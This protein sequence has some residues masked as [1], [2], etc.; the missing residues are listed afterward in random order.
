MKIALFHNLPPGGAKR[1]L[2]EHARL[3][4]ERGHV[5][6]AYIMSTAT[7]DYLS[8]TPLCRRVFV[9]DA[10][11]PAPGDRL[12]NNPLW[13]WTGQNVR[14]MVGEARRVRREVARLDALEATYREL[15][16]QIDAGGYDLVYVHHCRLL[17]S[18]ALLRFLKTPSV[19][20]CHDTLRHIHEWAVEEH[21]DYDRTPPKL[22]LSLVHGHRV[23]LPTL[24]LWWDQDRRNTASAR[25]ATMV[26]ANSSYSREA[27]LKSMGVN[28][29]VCDLGIDSEFFRPDPTVLRRHEVLSVG[30]IAPLKR[31][32][33]ILDA[34]ATIPEDRRPAMR[35]V[36]YDPVRY[37]EAKMSPEAQALA[38]RACERGVTLRF[39]KEVTDELV[40]DAY[41]SAG[42]VAFAPY[43]EPFGFVPL[44]AMACGAAVVGV[45]E[46]GVRETITDGV[47]GLLTER[48]VETF[49]AA[50]DRV[51][52]DPA[53][54]ERLGETGCRTVRE[55]WTW[56]R[57]ADRMEFLFAQAIKQT[58]LTS[59][60][61][62]EALCASR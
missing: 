17:L 52:T 60:A 57:S 22:G 58:P 32:D 27:I 31:H 12:M 39:S 44:E 29:R 40:R 46:A 13:R 38:D 1:A 47:T 10:P 35:I 19:Y 61:K 4:Q 2:W 20:F 26:F 43:L 34:I 15:A 8:L 56:E 28:A 37:G 59:A 9:H 14:K 36:G 51:L 48:D 54:A 5:L 41:Q 45:R 25:A 21:P 30:S 11:P 42:V 18:P 33:F 50:L 16:R 55:R 23:S 62:K 24:R 3:L 53:L 6:D 7:E 49:G